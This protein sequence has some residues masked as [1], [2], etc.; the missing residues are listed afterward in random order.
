V[1]GS[2]EALSLVAGLPDLVNL[3][4]M[5]QA[6]YFWRDAN[7]A[8]PH[9]LFTSSEFLTLFLRD[10]ALQEKFGTY[11]P[12]QFSSTNDTSQSPVAQKIIIPFSSAS[13]AVEYNYDRQNNNYLRSN[14]GAPHLDKLTNQQITVANVIVQ[15]V[16]TSLLDYE[17]GRLQM[18]VQ[19][20]GRAVVFHNG[21]ATEGKWR[22]TATTDRTLFFNTENTEIS[23]TPGNTWIEVLPDDR[24]I[25]YN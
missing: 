16:P 6:Q 23:F 21:Q 13:Y 4:Q 2:P 9:N 17:T 5:G 3:D 20:E 8:A 12:W 19:G 18:A 1:G 14:G 24:N 10:Y 7:I 15:F 11:S 22:K 25:E